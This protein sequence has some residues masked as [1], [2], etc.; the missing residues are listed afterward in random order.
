MDYEEWVN[1]NGDQ[2]N[3]RVVS[4][5][6]KHPI[7][8]FLHGGPGVCDRH[9]VLHYQGQLKKNY[10]M[11][12]WDQRGSGK[13]WHADIKKQDLHV[14]DYIQDARAMLEHLSK[15]FG[16]EKIIVA[17]HSWGTIIGTPLVTRYPE[18][19]AAYI[20]QGQF[21]EGT[22]N[23]LLSW[24]FCVDE[25]RSR[26]DKKTL[27]KL[28]GNPPVHGNYPTHKALM[29]QR[30]AL[31]RYGGACWKDRGGMVSSL[32]IPL[33]TMEGYKVKDIPK[34]AKGALYLTD[35][36]WPE[37]VDA[38][39]CETAPEIT[40]P[41]LL[42]IGRH[43]YN[44]PFPLAEKWFNQLNAPYKK[45]VWFSESAHSPIKEEPEKWG[46]AVDKFIQRHVLGNKDYL[47]K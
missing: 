3:I 19:V 36:L 2:Q 31:T 16:Q 25:A 37:V 20:G 44:T 4:E 9:W 41:V 12:F 7:I 45:L 40:V 46:L 6:I 38:D 30:D 21:V 42:T 26:N 39:F 23:E 27:E 14:E 8:L 18:H 22:D 13:S 35:V 11:V 43:D 29:A 47:K 15:E 34:Y 10:T 1:I 24:Q 28:E 5:D 17:G 33:F 32:L